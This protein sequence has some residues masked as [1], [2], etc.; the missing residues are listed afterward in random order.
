MAV[1]SIEWTDESHNPGIYGCSQHGKGCTFCYAQR[2]AERLANMGQDNYVGT[3]EGWRWTGNVRTVP[4]ERAVESI[5]RLPRRRGFDRPVRTFVTSMGDMLHESID[6]AWTAAVIV[7]MDQRPD[8]VFQVLTH[9]GTRWPL[10][11]ERVL[12]QLGRWP[13]NVWA[14]LS[15]ST[16]AEVEKE[17]VGL[18]AVPGTR[19]LSLEPLLGPVELSNVTRRADCVQRLGRPALEGIHWV[20]AGGESDPKAR[21]SHPYW[22]R[23]LRDQCVASGV[24][25]HFKQWGEWLPISEIPDSGEHLYR[26]R[27]TADPDWEDQSIVDEMEGRVC[28]VPDLVL[29]TDGTHVAIGDPHAFAGPS[30]M[31][32]FRVGKKAAGRELDG[33]TWDEFP[34]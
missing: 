12:E 2:M 11:V 25:F 34:A 5:L 26:S 1:T 6:P 13:N 33:R 17:I 28:T 20:I 9:R 10:V 21:P 23:S 19:F 29:H 15:A 24:P 8:R 16:Q 14:G 7:A 22:F 4:V 3:T 32:A 30:P 31:Q 18:L 27:R